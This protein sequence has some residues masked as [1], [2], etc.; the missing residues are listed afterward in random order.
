MFEDS[1]FDHCEHARIPLNR[2]MYL[3]DEIYAGEYEAMHLSIFS[4]GQY[5]A[6]GYV[7]YVAVRESREST[8]ELSWYPNVHDRFHEVLISL[9]RSKIRRCVGIPGWDLKPIIFVEGSWLDELHEK[10]FSVFG[11]IDAIGL[12]KAIDGQHLSRTKLLHLRDRIDE[13]ATRHSD[14][15]FISFGDSILVKSSWTVGS[16]DNDLT[17][18]YRP[19]ALVAVAREFQDI[20]LSTLE[21]GCYTIL[22]Q[23]HNE[24]YGDTLL[25]VSA[26][27]NHICLNSLGIPFARL[28][29]I[30]KAVRT[31]L[32]E[33][34][35]PP[36]E[37]YL[38]E[39]LYNSL[40][41][42][43][44]YKKGDRPKAAYDDTISGRSAYYYYADVAT[45]IENLRRT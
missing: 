16:V 35:H 9:P 43:H 38:D 19:E 30:E 25:H 18:T 12:R 36:A 10:V 2:D 34:A 26:T 33:G 40:D 5:R 14:V 13:L 8:L 22:T 17:Y 3:V 23:G 1:R 15:A 4:G 24:Y 39:S 6:V 21:L 29:A 41:L 45:I 20:F 7:S 37:I 31:A 44:E 28:T 42:R 27:Q 11:L 32:R